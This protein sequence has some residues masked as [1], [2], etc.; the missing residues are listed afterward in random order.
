MLSTGHASGPTGRFSP[1]RFHWPASS[2]GAG[3]RAGDRVLVY[4]D[5][6][7]EYIAAFFAVLRLG[8]VV[9]PV[10][11]SLT[12]EVVVFIT[13]DAE[14]ALV[15]TNGIFKKRLT[16]RRAGAPLAGPG[17]TGGRRSGAA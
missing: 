11:K 17:R 16:G 10:N 8:A 5:N 15:I 7:A 13:G 4:L 9:V 1:G 12:T 3:V 14:P 6:S 2:A